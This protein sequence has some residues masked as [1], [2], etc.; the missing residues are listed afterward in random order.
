MSESICV[1]GYDDNDGWMDDVYDDD[2]YDND[3]KCHGWNG[4]DWGSVK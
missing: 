2:V 3:D 1:T 4:S